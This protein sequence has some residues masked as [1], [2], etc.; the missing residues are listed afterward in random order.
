MV[1]K[2][3][4]RTGYSIIVA[5]GLLLLVAVLLYGLYYVNDVRTELWDSSLSTIIENTDRA[6]DMVTGKINA[7]KRSLQVQVN[8]LESL[9]SSDIDT[10]SFLL[11]GFDSKEY[12]TTL[13]VG[14]TT[15]PAKNSYNEALPD[16]A[17]A[18]INIVPPFL[19]SNSGKRVI[20][21]TKSMVFQD[22]VT[23][24]FIREIPVNDLN[25][26]FTVSFFQD[27]GHSYMID[28]KGDIL[29]RSVTT[30]GNKTSHN[31]FA[32][33]ENEA[34]NEQ[35]T[36][37]E[38]KELVAEGRSG[39]ALIKY[40][41]LDK[42]Y[43]FSPIESTQWILV[44]VVQEDIITEQTRNI[45]G[46]TFILSGLIFFG[47]LFLIGLLIIRERQNQKRIEQENILEKQMIIASN[48][49]VKTVVLGVDLDMDSYKI[50][51][52]IQ[53]EGY[54]ISQA[55]TFSELISSFAEI[56]DKEYRE[57]YVTCFGIS[58]LKKL[59]KEEHKYEYREF[60]IHLNGEKHW[61]AAE[62]VMVNDENNQNRL[63]YSSR[64]IDAAKKEEEDRRKVLQDALDMA[65]QANKAKSTF[66]SNMSHD[67]RTPMNAII[68]FATLASANIGNE[69]KIKDYLSKILSSS[70]HLLSLINDVLDMSRIE[71]GKINLEE[72]KANLSDIF[73]DIKTII[74]GQIHAK[75]LELYMDMMDVTDEDVFCDKT[76]LNQ[77]LLNLLSNAIKFT[78]AGGTVSVRIAQLPGASKGIGFYEIRVKDTGIGMSQEF[79]ER[80]FE[81]FERERTSTVSRIQ[82]TGLGMAISKN[83]IDMMGGTIEV[84]T[85][86]GKGTEFVI[87]L[88]LR[89][90]S[91]R[92]S[93]E[94]IAELEGLKALVV[95][96]DY[97]TC[98]SVTKMLEQVGMRSEWT[99]SGK[100][101]VLRAKNAFER[102][103]AFHAYIIDWRLPDMNGIEVTRQ[104]RRLGDDTPIIILTAYDWSDIEEEARNAGVTA[105]CSKPMFMSDLRETLLTAIGKTE[106]SVENP[107]LVS[108]EENGF[109]DKRLLLVED[110]ELNQEIALEILG[111]YGF[112]IDT[113]NNG[114]EAVEK[115]ASS[116]PGDYDL[117]LMDIQM[118]VMDGHEA[119]KRIRNLKEPT[120]ANIPILAMTANAFDE[121]RKAA[122]ECGMNGFLS[123]PIEIK[124]VI[125]A[126]SDLFNQE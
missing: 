88:T 114:L 115:V 99:I 120:L 7:E 110:N 9:D 69:E 59:T 28:G 4:K 107:L 21:L 96:D 35:S 58:N 42:L 62:A 68:G 1:K 82:G 112:M 32:I 18:T 81:P 30:S 64:V 13:I 103:D 39:W 55:S 79:A 72:Q 87:R 98:D 60:S 113:A 73:H 125:Q 33:F 95:D 11:N 10:I 19:S 102:S 56:V 5:S 49:E 116:K 41:G 70:N 34:E 97:N 85:E 6:A 109:K 71:S 75:Q 92:R 93:I 37:N 52:Q 14:I 111:E 23:G 57:E 45:L 126:L 106:E 3:K 74:S 53:H 63:V 26:A 47:F 16:V 108:D 91:E 44:S 36:I 17:D 15:Y 51:S 22:G 43:Y 83:I 25:D 8:A 86:Q 31:L 119:T 48:S 65:E 38:V 24:F 80:I 61:I 12:S 122:L 29:F 78:P 121:D 123:K 84:H 54:A 124:Q 40:N 117:I 2:N 76:R 20:A 50:I 104:I 94:K 27:R 90:Q 118:P 105:F 67:I 100:E 66:L 46:Q 77:V 101:A 89:L